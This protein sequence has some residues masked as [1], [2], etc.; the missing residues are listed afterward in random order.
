[1]WKKV[2]FLHTS[3]IKGCEEKKTSVWPFG[4]SKLGTTRKIKKIFILKT[5]KALQNRQLKFFRPSP[6]E[7]VPI[8]CEQG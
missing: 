8:H 5:P 2:S 6:L 1:M 7:N 4:H 3:V